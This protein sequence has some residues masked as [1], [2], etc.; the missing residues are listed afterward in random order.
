[1][2]YNIAIHFVDIDFVEV[3]EVVEVEPMG[4]STNK[5]HPRVRRT[6]LLGFSKGGLNFNRFLRSLLVSEINATE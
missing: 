5:N 3:V 2:M 6:R 4:I 1:M